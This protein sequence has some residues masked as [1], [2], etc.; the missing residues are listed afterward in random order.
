M[1]CADRKDELKD[2]NATTSPY[3]VG[4]LNQA[5]ALLAD[6]DADPDDELEAEPEADLRAAHPFDEP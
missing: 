3:L 6:P 2:P 1:R 5:L 4:S